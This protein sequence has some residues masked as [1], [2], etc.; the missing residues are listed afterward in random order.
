[1]NH[2]NTQVA[3]IDAETKQ[4][5]QDTV[6]LPVLSSDESERVPIVLNIRRGLPKATG[7]YV[8][9][10]VHGIDVIFT[11]DTGASVS[12]LSKNI[13]DA[14]PD[15]LKP[16]LDPRNPPLANANGQT[17]PSFGQALFDVQFGALSMEMKFIVA[18]IT[19]DVLIGDDI[20][21]GDKYGK[22][23]LLLS[24]NMIILRDVEI[25]VETGGYPSCAR[26]VQLADNCTVPPMTEVILEVY[27]ERKEVER[28]N[29]FLI[30][31]NEDF[32][33]KYSVLLAPSINNIKNQ[34][35][36]QVR[37][38]NP[39]PTSAYLPQD[40]VIG[41]AEPIEQVEVVADHEDEGQFQNFNTIRNI[42]LGNSDSILQAQVKEE[43]GNRESTTDID[44]PDHLKE[45]YEE[46]ITGRTP[47]EQQTLAEFFMQFADVFSR[48]DLD[49]GRTNL[50]EHIIE[51][52]D[53]PP[54]K[55]APRRVPLAF[56]DEADGAIQKLFD[57]GTVRESTSPWASPLVFVRKK[58][59]QVRP[60]VDYRKLNAITTKD[61]FPLP[62][63]QDCFDAVADA[64]LFSSMDITAAYNQIPV[65]E[66]D[67]PKTA[68]VTKYGL[69][70]FT[71][72]PF[73][74][75]NAPATFQRVM[76]LALAG[77]QWKTCLVYLDDVLV[78]SKTF[79]EHIQRLSDVLKRIR[80]AHLKLKPSKCHFSK[81]K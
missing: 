32:T 17:I 68:F 34:V 2:L 37:V 62:R 61:A 59:G 25:K 23:D 80:Q 77:L 54:I 52:G 31:P 60:C 58:N 78:F 75:C 40:S 71:T 76:E 57:Q 66:S 20:L 6:P 22:A 10:E 46:C 21:L 8:K 19:D 47:E 49:I 55:L 48:N 18:D 63:T 51:T 27:V 5:I 38:M 74:L 72:M 13:Y 64:T 30:E 41:F 35:T 45:L 11:I 65:R 3:T 53:A 7:V 12:L 9:G 81:M 79:E 56:A 16:E 39:F 4:T 44:V 70:E 42:Q 14:M 1:M 73:G 43:D 29:E 67:I 26:R 36:Q 33:G 69:F 15:D 50:T 28:D 24:Q